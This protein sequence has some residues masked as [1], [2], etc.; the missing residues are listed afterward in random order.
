MKKFLM[1]SAAVIAVVAPSAVSAQ[2]TGSQDFEDTI[3]V[4]GARVS[5]GI[6]GVVLPDTTKAKGVLTKASPSRGRATP[7]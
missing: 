1:G 2:S 4:T 6:Q 3:V 5:S 7:F